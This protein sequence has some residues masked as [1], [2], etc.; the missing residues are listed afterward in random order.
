MFAPSSQL[1]PNVYV[2][3]RLRG[4]PCLPLRF[5]IRKRGGRSCWRVQTPS[6]GPVLQ[7]WRQSDTGEMMTWLQGSARG[8]LRITVKSAAFEI[9]LNI[10]ELQH[11]PLNMTTISLASRMKTHFSRDYNPQSGFKIA[12]KILNL[13]FRALKALRAGPGTRNYTRR[14]TGWHKNDNP[15][16]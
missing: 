11:W 7:T 4:W 9:V 10:T 13:L 1:I 6:P 15:T 14:S 8:L 2:W 5:T 3:K 16:V 12:V